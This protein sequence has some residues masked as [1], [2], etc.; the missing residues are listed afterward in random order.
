VTADQFRA[1]PEL[2]SA[3]HDLLQNSVL[4][5][6]LVCLKDES[7]SLDIPLNSDALASVRVAAAK[8]AWDACINMFVTLSVPLPLVNEND[9]QPTWGVDRNKFAMKEAV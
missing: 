9:D 5:N 6:A 4:A 2:V 7:P 3:L 1:N 8:S